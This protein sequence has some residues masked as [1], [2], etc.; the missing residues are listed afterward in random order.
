MGELVCPG[1][2]NLAHC[3]GELNLMPKSSLQVQQFSA[4]KPYLIGMMA[5]LV[6][7]LFAFG[8]FNDRIASIKRK[9]LEKL[10]PQLQKLQADNTKV[11]A[12]VKRLT[13]AQGEATQL[14]AWLE[15]RSYWGNL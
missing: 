4:K 12:E 9:S 10:E 13:V 2:R 3:P 14:A 5:C 6:A 7:I 11:E 1:L 8:Y 15:D